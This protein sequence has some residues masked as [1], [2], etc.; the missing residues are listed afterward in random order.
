MLKE[1]I[2]SDALLISQL[3]SSHEM[4]KI[5]ECVDMTGYREM[6]IYLVLGWLSKENK[7]SYL[8]L[9]NELYIKL[10]T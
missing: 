10:N 1:L 5:E 8:E 6:Y 4:L 9:D 3:L 7:I 2:A